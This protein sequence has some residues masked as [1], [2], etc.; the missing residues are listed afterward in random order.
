[1]RSSKYAIAAVILG[2]LLAGPAT[3]Q[4]LWSIG[5]NDGSYQEFAGAGDY[6]ACGKA[7]P[8][9]VVFREGQDDTH[10]AWPF[11]HPGPSDGWAGE[12]PHEFRVQFTLDKAPESACRVTLYLVDAH[13][14]GPPVVSVKVNDHACPDMQIAAGTG[15]ASLTDPGAGRH[16]VQ[17]MAFPGDWLVPGENALSITAAGGSWMLYDAVTLE[18]GIPSAPHVEGVAASGTPLFRT[19]DG[20]MKQAVRVEIQNTGLEGT[21]SLSL[22]GDPAGVQEITIAQG[23]QS[24]YLLVTPFTAAEPRRVLL[25]AG[26]VISSAEFEAK[27]QRQ[28]TLYVAA[29]AHTDI[30]YTDLQEKC[31]ALHVDNAMLALDHGA[32]NPDFKWNLEVF[33]QA[34]WIRELKPDALPR[35]EQQIRAGRI[36]LTGLYLNMLTGLCSGEEMMWLLRPAQ[37]Y[38]RS[39]GTPVVMA[40]LN[41]VPSSVGTLPMFLRH[42]GIRYFSEAINEDRGPVFLHADPEMNQS[43]FWWEAPD[44]S[45]VM[46][47]FTRTYFQ[48]WQ[49]QMN[50]SVA[51]MENTLPGF[52]DRFIREDYPGDALF[53][54]GAFLDNCAM[55]PQYA[56]VAAEW[57]RKWDF[58]H[59]VLSTADAY[60]RH[61][62]ENFGNDLPVYRGD[63]GVFWEDG[64]AS[65]ALETS[66][67]RWAKANLSTA[68]KWQTLAA[69]SGAGDTSGLDAYANTWKEILYY[70]EHT[71]GSAAS[72]GDPGGE[73]TT[74]QWARKAAFADRSL[75]QSR[76]WAAQGDAALARLAAVPENEK[77]D[78]VLVSN[79]LSWGRDIMVTLPKKTR[80]RA[81]RD[82]AADTDVP[83]QRT[84]GGELA[85]VAAAVPGMGYRTYAFVAEEKNLGEGLLKNAGNPFTWETPAFVLHI[86]PATGGV[87]RL[88]EKA[89][90]K[91]WV[92]THSGYTLNQFLHV[93]GGNNTG[94]IHP[95]APTATD[96]AEATHDAAKVEL[97]ENGP[98]RAVLR[99]TRTGA[100]VS[101]VDTD[102]IVHA[103]GTLDFVNTLDKIETLEKEAGYFV[104]PFGLDAP[105]AA[106]AYF[107][108]PYGVVEADLEQIP[109]A[110]REWYCV[111]TFAAVSNGSDTA[112]VAAPDTPL[113]TSG[114]INR[115]LWPNRLRGN[116]HVLYAY[117]YNNYWHTNYKA[118]QGGNLRCA[119][120][121]RLSNGAFDPVA[122]TRFGW[123]R[124]LDMT[125]DR[126]ASVVVE[127]APVTAANA[128]LTLSE[129]P[130]VLG[131]LLPAENG[132][133]ARLYNPSVQAATTALTLPGQE[134]KET[135]L[136]D[137]FGE[138]GT[139]AEAPGA[140]RI[141]ARGI[142][143]V[144]LRTK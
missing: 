71:W 128:F 113:F 48:V 61:I 82:V 50:E 8:G 51:A 6:A 116:R 19:V 10:A 22:E 102:I 137:L 83:V 65:S 134:L 18:A 91:E 114:D 90:E 21:G 119:F 11:V 108:L 56:D 49:I 5:Q 12:R 84:A 129:G 124:A 125:P 68:E 40:S 140:V 43:P 2:I 13:N 141:P 31:M 112:C 103:D 73:Q 59:V 63:M 115:G 99:I 45:R 93:T 126:S 122:A 58:P 97:I 110:C 33:A 117:V 107:E 111:N 25:Q 74:G 69:A 104:F 94:M 32:A 106:H 98:V 130:V 85:F 4:I 60:F 123:A 144:V 42:A 133:M 143:T 9:D 36:G 52:M 118:S 78:Y 127:R 34:D 39:L 105:D 138:N 142:A 14:G 67:V 100:S 136:T 132:I 92:D 26:D 27:P 47:I 23:T 44:G 1:M 53:I 38:G 15:D 16:T 88:L 20:V 46:A 139:A 55:S 109:G 96:L 64:A 80:A 76:D 37:R 66:M 3:A 70:D 135:L 81:I 28:W 24:H 30:G 29:S 120:S 7:F 87:D 77:G 86:D 41:D 101:P 121:V 79:P 35:L 57:N 72:I 17:S 62:E 89:A 131:D 54:N 75:K 95:G